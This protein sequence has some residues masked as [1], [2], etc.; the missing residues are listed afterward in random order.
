MRRRIGTPGL[1]ALLLIPAAAWGS[2]PRLVPIGKGWARNSVN[3][4]IFRTNSVTTHGDTQYAA[5]YD[6][7]GHVVLARRTLGSTDWTVKRTRYRGNV[8]DAHNGI[9]MAVDGTGTLHVSWDH[10]NHP[11]RY[12]RGT[13]PGSLELTDKMPM[14]GKSERRVTYPEFFNLPDGGLLFLYRDGA[15]G[16]GN[17]MLNRYDPRTKT[18][19]VARHV[20]IDGEGRRNAYTNQIAVDASGAWHLSWCWRETGNVATN[21]DVCYAKSADGGN[22]WLKS[23]GERYELPIRAAN[24][25]YA[26][27]IPQKSE[28]INQTSMTVD[29]GGRP[30]IATYWRPKGTKVPQYHLVWHDG[31][32]WRTSQVTRRRTPFTLSGGGTRRIP[33]S[34]PQVAVGKDGAVYVIFRDAERGDVVS[35]AVSRDRARSRWDIRDLTRRSVGLWEP[36]YDRALWR[37][38]GVLHIFHQR[39]GQGQGEKLE[40]VPPQTVS[41]LEWSPKSR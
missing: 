38:D 27:R 41:I 20:V 15:S 28:L 40:D 8:R 13:G 11:L 24:A 34:R 35:V 14:T 3:C 16:R 37:R 30:L 31:R 19:S 39:V 29:S 23:T 12:V 10:H 17:S 5:Y 4:T 9:V 36:T 32:T 33:I 25:E 18:W 7:D 1:A 6:A 22:T 2:P 26:C 21:H